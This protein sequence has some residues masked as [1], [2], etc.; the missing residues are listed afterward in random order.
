M[1]EMKEIITM[2]Q[3]NRLFLM[4]AVVIPVI[5]LLVG[6]LLGSRRGNAGRGALTGLLFGLIGPANLLLWNVYNAITDRLGLD[7]VKNLLVNLGLFI[8]LGV[9]A[10]LICGR[11]WIRPSTSETAEPEASTPDSSG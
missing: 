10:G 7:T 6:G 8:A 4:L 11:Y 2:E 1:D 9:V 5:G 3:A